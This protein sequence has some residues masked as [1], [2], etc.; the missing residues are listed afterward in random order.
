[1]LDASI[2]EKEFCSVTSTDLAANTRS[3]SHE[4]RRRSFIFTLFELVLL[5]KSIAY[6]GASFFLVEKSVIKIDVVN[7]FVVEIKLLEI[8]RKTFE[9]ANVIRNVF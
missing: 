2:C 1:M 7:Y 4:N 8:R 9:K 3:T 6:Y 5:N